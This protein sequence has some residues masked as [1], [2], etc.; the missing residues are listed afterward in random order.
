MLSFCA[1]LVSTEASEGC[2]MLT[3]LTKCHP[4]HTDFSACPFPVVTLWTL[5]L[6]IREHCNSS[7]LSLFLYVSKANKVLLPTEFEDEEE[8]LPPE[9]DQ[10]PQKQ[11]GDRVGY[12]EES[13]PTGRP[14]STQ[15]LTCQ[16]QELYVKVC[17][18]KVLMVVL[19][20][21]ESE[22]NDEQ[23]PPE[24]EQVPQKQPSDPAGYEEESKPTGRLCST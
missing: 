3:A 18:L 11:P 7:Y 6:C 15:S 9:T 8:Q 20:P 1:T 23:L 4:L 24:N 17:L 22:G 10:M 12:E 19:V 2:A 13:E 14:R 16:Y 5:D 21:A